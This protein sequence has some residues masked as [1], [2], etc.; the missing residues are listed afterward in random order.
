MSAFSS[1][2]FSDTNWTNFLRESFF[3]VHHVFDLLFNL[4][5]LAFLKKTI[6]CAV[7]RRGKGGGVRKSKT[8]DYPTTFAL[9][10]RAFVA[11]R[12]RRR[13]TTIYFPPPQHNNDNDLGGKAFADFSALAYVES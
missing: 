5:F 10:S 11:A 1:L 12:R 3:Y 13:A 4:F 7:Y 8:I 6:T 2:F 9:H